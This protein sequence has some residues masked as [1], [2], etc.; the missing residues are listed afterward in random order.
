MKARP[1]PFLAYVTGV[2]TRRDPPPPLCRRRTRDDQIMAGSLSLSLSFFLSLRAG[3][4]WRLEAN[5]KSKILRGKL[6]GYKG[7]PLR[8]RFYN[9]RAGA[10]RR[11]NSPNN[12]LSLGSRGRGRQRGINESRIPQLTLVAAPMHRRV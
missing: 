8:R 6:A 10:A 12:A 2:A 9:A 3:F 7:T 11:E 4:E 5:R 1:H